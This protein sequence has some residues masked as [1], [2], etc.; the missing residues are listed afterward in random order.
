MRFSSIPELVA[1]SYS[2]RRP[3]HPSAV[4]FLGL[5]SEKLET[6]LYSFNANGMFKRD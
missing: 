6:K 3:Y 5:L 4:E 2:L 1:N